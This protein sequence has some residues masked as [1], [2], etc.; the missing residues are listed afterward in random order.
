MNLNKN[1]LVALMAAMLVPAFA[2]TAAADEANDCDPTVVNGTALE[3]ATVA[4][5]TYKAGE[6]TLTGTNPLDIWKI[7]ADLEVSDAKFTPGPGAFTVSIFRLPSGGTC[8]EVTLGSGSAPA[9]YDLDDGGDYF[10]K[11]SILDPD[12]IVPYEV[13][14]SH[15]A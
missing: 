14:G 1:A 7:P 15:D 12:L 10:L 2:P 6:R 9:S 13:V 11:V 8:T 4:S 3:M 5:H